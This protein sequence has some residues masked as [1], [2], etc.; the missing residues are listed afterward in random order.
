M[1]LG[2][3]YLRRD[4]RW[5]SGLSLRA[6]DPGYAQQETDSRLMRTVY[7]CWGVFSYVYFSIPHCS[8]TL[9]PRRVIACL[10]HLLIQR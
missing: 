2:S 7:P 10:G 6:P 5:G 1:S 8:T 3:T 4:G 9:F